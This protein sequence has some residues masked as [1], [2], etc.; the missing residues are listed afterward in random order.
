MEVRE[1][2]GGWDRAASPAPYL[3]WDL[4]TVGLAL[5]AALRLREVEGRLGLGVGACVV[6]VGG[7]LGTQVELRKAGAH[8]ARLAE[9]LGARD[10]GRRRRRRRRRRG[11]GAVTAL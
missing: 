3:R 2:S 9:G 11:G 5:K 10:D 6:V 1:G 4:L 8:A 7:V